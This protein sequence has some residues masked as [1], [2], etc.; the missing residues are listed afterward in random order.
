ML[1]A[2]QA[3]EDYARRLGLPLQGISLEEYL[4]GATMTA[5]PRNYVT[6]IYLPI[7]EG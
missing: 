4:V 1:P 2:Y 6:R 7:Q 3:L 5:D